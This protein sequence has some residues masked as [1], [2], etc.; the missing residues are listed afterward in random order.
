MLL[1]DTIMSCLYIPIRGVDPETYI[2]L[3]DLKNVLG[4]T[5]TIYIGYTLSVDVDVFEGQIGIVGTHGIS[6]HYTSFMKMCNE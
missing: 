2:L 5:C 4:Y 6:V 3:N 1:V